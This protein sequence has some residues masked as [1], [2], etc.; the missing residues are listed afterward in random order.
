MNKYFRILKAALFE[1]LEYRTE[2]FI[3]VLG[4]G[5]RLVISLFLW[6]AVTQAKGGIIAGYTFDKILLYFFLIQIIATFVFNDSGFTINNDIH[7]GD[8]SN[9]LVKPVRYLAY[10]FTVEFGFTLTRVI[11]GIVLFGGILFAVKPEVFT[12]IAGGGARFL[13]FFISLIFSML[14]NFHLVALLALFSFWIVSSQRLL[15][16]YFGIINIFSGLILPLDLFPPAIFAVLK[17]L[18]F[19]YLF[20]FPLEILFK[21]DMTPAAFASTVIMPQL[22]QLVIFSLLLNLLY[23]A[24]I[25]HYEAVGR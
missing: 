6:F 24:G 11:I 5:I 15:F 13:L 20:Y 8:F 17:F 19:P 1:A 22:G 16:V 18:P 2:F 21:A 23:R 4:W 25:K 3:R 12:L 10:R 7:Y 14:L 9:Y